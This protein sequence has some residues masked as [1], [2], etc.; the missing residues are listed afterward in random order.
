ML[1]VRMVKAIRPDFQGKSNE[2]EVGQIVADQTNNRLPVIFSAFW[3][4]VFESGQKNWTI[5]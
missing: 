1:P 2:N 5:R 3:A 4:P